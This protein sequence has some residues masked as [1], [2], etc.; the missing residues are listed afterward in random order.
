MYETYI[1]TTTIQLR[2][3]SGRDQPML[4][5]ADGFM[6][7]K[8]VFYIPMDK[9]NKLPYALRKVECYA[10]FKQRLKTF[11]FKSAFCC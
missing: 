11:L 4:V 3:G 9:W 6:P 8:C 7:N 5:P 1:P 10:V 2:I